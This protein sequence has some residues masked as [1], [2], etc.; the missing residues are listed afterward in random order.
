MPIYLPPISRRRFLLGSAAVAAGVALGRRGAWAAD[1]DPDRIALLSDVH[2]AADNAL[3]ARGIVMA[4]HLAKASGD[5][6]G[7]GPKPSMA[8][9]AGDLAYNSGESADY[10]TLLS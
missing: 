10:A 8:F 2:I 1:G 7:M 5:V 6:I 9:I 4:D 3:A